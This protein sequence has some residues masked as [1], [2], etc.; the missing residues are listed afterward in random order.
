MLV[1]TRKK[2]EGIVIGKD[3]KVTVLE[4]KGDLVKLGIEAPK[5]VNICRE[6]IYQDVENL[7][8]MGAKPTG[9]LKKLASYIT[10]RE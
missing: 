9:D 4:V 5:W 3:I 10:K 8:K 2:D 6:E 7:N 1:L